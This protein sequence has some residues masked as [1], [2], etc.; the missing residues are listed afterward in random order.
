MWVTCQT[1]RK[2]DEGEDDCSVVFEKTV[3]LSDLAYLGIMV[4]CVVYTHNCQSNTHFVITLS[5]SF[6]INKDGSSYPPNSVVVNMY[7]GLY[8]RPEVGGVS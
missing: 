4:G 7:E 3:E 1:D 2:G 6:Q 8:S 5:L